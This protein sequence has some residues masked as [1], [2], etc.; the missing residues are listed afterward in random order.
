MRPSKGFSAKLFA[1][2]DANRALRRRGDLDIGFLT[3]VSF[4]LQLGHITKDGNGRAGED[5]VVLLAAEAGRTLTFSPTGYRGTLGGPGYPLVYRKYAEGI[6]FLEIVANFFKYLGL[7]VPRPISPV[8]TDI[9]KALD[10]IV[11]SDG[12]NR[13]DWPDGL[14]SAV[15]GVYEEIAEDP[16]DDRKLFQPSSAYRCYAEFLA[17][18]LIYF[19]L[20]LENP[21]QHLASMKARYP[22][23]FSCSQYSLDLAFGRT[24]HPIPDD[25]GEACDE[26]V[27]LIEAEKLERGR[28]DNNRLEKA[29]ARVETEDAEIGQLLRHE[30]SSISPIEEDASKPFLIPLSMTG[31]KLDEFIRAKMLK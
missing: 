3:A 5:M 22:V 7:S 19:T 10:T 4:C 16:G 20:C 11:S 29:V 30:L 24:Y 2:I 14:G 25:I 27:A 15:A 8:I 17:G 31:A 18:E 6:L 13:L 9:L 26:V 28:R 1:A 21:T 23:S 12:Q